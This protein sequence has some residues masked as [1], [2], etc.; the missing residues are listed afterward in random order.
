MAI[1]DNPINNSFFSMICAR[2]FVAAKGRT[3]R[4]GNKTTDA[5]EDHAD[6]R[7]PGA[8]EVF[9]V[10]TKPRMV[11]NQA[12]NAPVRGPQR[13]AMTPSPALRFCSLRFP[14]IVVAVTKRPDRQPNGA[15]NGKASRTGRGNQIDDV[16]RRPAVAATTIIPLRMV[17]C[18]RSTGLRA[19]DIR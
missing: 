2:P 10:V 6:Y 14:R 17:N 19:R 4:R 13:I 9:G 8:L 15:T 16:T 3:E 7:V 12:K 18:T 1:L 5:G 11:A